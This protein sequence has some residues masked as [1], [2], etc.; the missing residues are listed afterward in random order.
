MPRFVKLMNRHVSRKRQLFK[1][2]SLGI[3]MADLLTPRPTWAMKAI[4]AQRAKPP[5]AQEESPVFTTA[6]AFTEMQ[7]GGYSN[8]TKDKGGETKFGISKRSYPKLDIKN[9]NR[10]QA[11]EIYK[12]DYWNKIQGDNLPPDVARV[13]FDM[14]IHAGVS[15]ASKHLQLAIGAK[16]DGIVGRRTLARLENYLRDTDAHNLAMSLSEKRKWYYSRIANRDPSQRDFLPKWLERAESLKS[17][18]QREEYIR[19]QSTLEKIAERAL[20]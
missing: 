18:L 6:R 14:A 20:R 9:L 12:T 16:P 10:K 5:V 4:M 7:E 19:R 17:I 1:L 3:L 15:A 13:V 11:R 2:F 8:R